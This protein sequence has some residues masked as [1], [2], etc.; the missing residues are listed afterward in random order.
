MSTVIWTLA[1][2]KYGEDVGT[3]DVGRRPTLYPHLIPTPDLP[4]LSN[5]HCPRLVLARP[6]A[7]Q[8]VNKADTNVFGE[9]GQWRGGSAIEAEAKKMQRQ[10]W[11]QSIGWQQGSTVNFYLPWL[12]TKS[13]GYQSHV[14]DRK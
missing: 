7:K 12:V 5:S 4:T 8:A 9:V 11:P 14:K 3:S 13:F 1:D 6:I 2:A 10:E